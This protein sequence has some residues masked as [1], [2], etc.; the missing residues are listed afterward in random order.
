MRKQKM[1]FLPGQKDAFAIGGI[2]SVFDKQSK[3]SLAKIAK[4]E[5]EEQWEGRFAAAAL[6]NTSDINEARG[7]G[8]FDEY[9]KGARSLAML[10]ALSK[11][12]GM[13]SIDC[14]SMTD[15]NGQEFQWAI[16][17]DNGII[18]SDGDRI[19][20]KMVDYLEAEGELQKE[21][22]DA[23]IKRHTHEESIKIL[24]DLVAAASKKNMIA[25]KL[26][27]FKG[28]RK[29]FMGLLLLMLIIVG[30]GVGGYT[31]W[32]AKQEEEAR[33]QAKIRLEE[34]AKKNI[35][36]LKKSEFPPV[37]IQEPYPSSVIA[38]I[39]AQNSK[40]M[41]TV[42]GWI[43]NGL[44]YRKGRFNM[45]YVK[46]PASIFLPPPGKVDPAKPNIS[47]VQ[48]PIKLP[49]KDRK[50]GIM[51]LDDAANWLM[52][53]SQGK[54]YKTTYK[55][56]PRKSKTIPVGDNQTIVVHASYQEYSFTLADV[57]GQTLEGLGNILEVPGLVLT[58]VTYN[59]GTWKLQG[60]IYALPK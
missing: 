48:V 22:P 13:Q 18:Q 55:L 51:T 47:M 44:D 11:P 15:S 14:F 25:A 34:S 57:K 49:G 27:S 32:S 43:L 46:D 60:V 53:M 5:N 45:V 6:H 9:E 37:W 1:I 42:N 3:D 52:Q 40:S 54:P 20:E 8:Y 23:E 17:V 2:W 24:A 39:L 16:V 21:F 4:R 50:H 26:I 7:V 30:I 33:I 38:A 12:S 10:V 41:I 29:R 56:L 31:W 19:F 58:S 35:E 36:A 28:V 59:N